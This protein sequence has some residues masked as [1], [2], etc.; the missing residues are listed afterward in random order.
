VTLVAILLALAVQAPADK[1]ALTVSSPELRV[2]IDEFR[3]LYEKGDVLVLDVRS[4]EAYRNGHIPGALSVPLDSVDGKT[5]ELRS[6]RRPIV[7][8]CS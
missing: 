8:Y 3:K 5:A 2:S 6:E 1:P 7:T 4:A